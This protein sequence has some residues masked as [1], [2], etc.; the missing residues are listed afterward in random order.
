MTSNLLR[1][2][3]VAGC[4]AVALCAV[5][6]AR[7]SVECQGVADCTTVT[8]PWVAVTVPS[9]PTD[10]GAMWTGFCPTPSQ[11]EGTDWATPVEA[12]A[13]YLD[14]Y[15]EQASDNPIYGIN[16]LSFIALNRVPKPESFQPLLGCGSGV[17]A[18]RASG[19]PNAKTVGCSITDP[20]CAREH[21]VAVHA[22]AASHSY[23]FTHRCRKGER[24]V[25]AGAGVGFFTKRAPSRRELGELK[26]SRTVRRGRATY[27][28][29]TGRHVGDNEKVQAQ[30][31]TFCA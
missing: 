1:P 13:H 12:H 19:V 4:L 27:R 22:L 20:R 18:A 23:K 28:V 30:V 3:L 7:A 6:A 21:R 24:L 31:H 11:V 15:I 2:L 29:R 16:G 5:P 17:A 9:D 10:Y 25:K 26:V 8:G 14:V